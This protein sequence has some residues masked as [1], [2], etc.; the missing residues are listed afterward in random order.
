MDA[1]MRRLAEIEERVGHVLSRYLEE[2]GCPCGYRQFVYWAGKTQGPGWQDNVQN[3]L[4]RAALELDVYEETEMDCGEWGYEG[5]LFCL[6]CGSLWKHISFEWR[7]LAYHERLLLLGEEDPD[8][9]YE[10]MAAA[11]VA[12]TVGHGPGGIR[13]LTLEQWVSFMLGGSSG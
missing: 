7:M 9:L 2:R 13:S 3:A 5:S 8:G 4:V 1:A 10:P 12:A 11:D 6:A